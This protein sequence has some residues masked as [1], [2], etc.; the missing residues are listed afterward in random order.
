M[1][2]GEVLRRAGHPVGRCVSL[3]AN[4]W[5]TT[6]PIHRGDNQE[7]FSYTSDLWHCFV[8]GESGGVVGLGERLGVLARKLPRPEIE[9]MPDLRVVFERDREHVV[10]PVTLRLVRRLADERA[11]IAA[12]ADRVHVACERVQGVE[13]PRYLDRAALDYQNDPD[14]RDRAFDHAAAWWGEAQ[15]WRDLAHTLYGAIAY[16][17]GLAL[18]D[19]EAAEVLA[20]DARGCPCQG[21]R[22]PE[23]GSAVRPRLV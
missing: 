13:I 5:R 1:T 7:G 21:G 23:R 18:R 20:T 6:C 19:P 8:C 4:R 16:D 22:W 14:G 2:V 3:R 12:A 10:E 15:R 11:V 9:G 17:A